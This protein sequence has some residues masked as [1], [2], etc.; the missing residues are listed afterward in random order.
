MSAAKLQRIRDPVHNLIELAADEFEQTLWRVIQT[1]PF[2]RLRRIRQLGFSELVYPGAT[3]TRF[4]HSLGVFH[5]A[6]A[7]M[8]IIEQHVRMSGGH[9]FRDHKAQV[10]LAAALL[11]DVG[12]G[13]F[14]HAFEPIGKTLDLPLAQHEHVSQ[15]LICDS[16]I[17]DVLNGELVSG[18]ATD[19]A[20]LIGRK[21]PGNLYDAVV[22][23]QFDADRLDYMQRDALMTGVQSSVDPTWLM[24]NLEIA[25]VAT[26]ADDETSG[27]VETLVLGPK[28]IRAAESYV[29]TLFHLYPTV[30]LHKTTRGAEMLF[31]GLMRRLV[32][33][34]KEGDA[35]RTGLSEKHPIRR[36]IEDPEKLRNALALDDAVFWGALPMLEE[37]DDEEI[38]RLAT[39]L[40]KRN[41]MR[42]VDIRLRAEADLPRGQDEKHSAYGARV[43]LACQNIK[44]SLRTRASEMKGEGERIFVDS[45]SRSPYKRFQESQ[46]PLNQILVRTGPGRPQDMAE[47]SPIIAGAETFN[48][49][50]AYVFRDD[51]DAAKVIENEIR[52]EIEARRHA[53][54]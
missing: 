53:D 14:S 26:G 16:E 15:L 33:L 47:L 5:T 24:A 51:A 21:E 3:H 54:P 6:R 28:A 41:L 25:S 17:A 49:C 34:G 46:T 52:T 42:C 27:E 7:L 18:F 37:A 36:F 31:G 44:A 48:I 40:K 43:R 30:Y 45:Y 9:V 4:A 32:R 1:P 8:R 12:H 35:G 20:L 23:S 2:Q 50:R 39:C 11:H 29:L 10:A 19:V 13:M 22:S 38:R